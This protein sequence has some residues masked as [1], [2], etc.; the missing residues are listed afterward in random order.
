MAS[1]EGK[2]YTV[3]VVDDDPE[4]MQLLTDGLEL[5]GNFTVV[6][7]EDG[8]QGLVHFFEV[9]PDCVIIDVKM[10]NLDGYQLV[11]ALRGDPESAATPLI[12]L[13]ALAQEKNKFVG[14]AFGADQYLVKPVTPRALIEAIHRAVLTSEEDRQERLRALLA[15]EEEADHKR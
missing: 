2:S 4:I 8:E 11:R 7:A 12:M 9:H 10:P 5:L 13:T 15:E 6:Q 3:L 1:A 14:L